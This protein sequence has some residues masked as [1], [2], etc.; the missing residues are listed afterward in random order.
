MFSYFYRIYDK[1]KQKIVVLAIFTDN[2]KNY[3]PNNF[4]YE[5]YHTELS[6]KYRTYKILEQIG[7]EKRIT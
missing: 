7:K 2:D 3:M 5:F 4:K 1:F 6:Y